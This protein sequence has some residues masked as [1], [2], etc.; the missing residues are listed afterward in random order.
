MQ[1]FLRRR[2]FVYRET[3]RLYV[4]QTSSIT[5]LQEALDIPTT[6]QIPLDAADYTKSSCTSGLKATVTAFITWTT[7]CLQ[8]TKSQRHGVWLKVWDLP[9]KI[10]AWPHRITRDLWRRPLDSKFGRK[11]TQAVHKCGESMNHSWIVPLMSLTLSSNSHPDCQL[12]SQNKPAPLPT[13]TSSFQRIT[14]TVWP[15]ASTRPELQQ[16]YFCLSNNKLGWWCY[17][18][19][20]AGVS[21]RAKAWSFGGRTPLKEHLIV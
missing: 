2:L 21:L 1:H 16:K 4:G 11:F 14:Q 17:Y 15:L 18:T 9:G 7:I 8:K 19:V 20:K 6:F 13:N 12:Q 10:H 5:S 3:Q